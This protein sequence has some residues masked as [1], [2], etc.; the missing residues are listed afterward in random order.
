MHQLDDTDRK[1]LALLVNDA[2]L[3]LKEIAREVGLSSP[4]AGERLRR[5]QERGIVR[6]FTVEMEPASLGFPVQAIV[7]VHPLPGKVRLVQELLEGIAEAA[8]CDKVTGDDCF[9]A[10][11]FV[12]SI[13]HLDSVLE[14]ISDHAETS[15]AVV[16]SQTVR[17]RPPPLHYS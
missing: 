15:T 1:L 11:V 10:R 12:R 3:S 8:E 13:G 4:S 5:L 6:R 14:C 9:V 7:R 2:R 17:R 16:K